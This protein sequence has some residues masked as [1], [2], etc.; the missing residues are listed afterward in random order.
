ML[1]D[2]SSSNVRDFAARGVTGAMAKTHEGAAIELRTHATTF[3]TW[4]TDTRG[5]TDVNVMTGYR[6]PK[7]TRAE[8]LGRKA[9]RRALTDE[10]TAKVWRACGKLGV[11]G[12]LARMCL[13]GGPRRSE[14]TFIEWGQHVMD[15]RIT[16]DAR[17]TKMGLHHDI[18]RTALVNQVLEDAKRFQR[19]TSDLVFPSG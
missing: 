18:P 13:L 17:W 15:D 1:T 10:E 16:F 3:L 11:F 7:E 6:K 19:A 8:K 9:K 14:P 2:P 5:L 4:A 12:P